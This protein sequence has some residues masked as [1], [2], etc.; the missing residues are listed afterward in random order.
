[1]ERPEF[2]QEER[3]LA[4]L[5]WEYGSPELKKLR[6]Q[7][8]TEAQELEYLRA[9]EA[10]DKAKR[11]DVAARYGITVEKKLEINDLIDMEDNHLSYCA[12]CDGKTCK[13]TCRPYTAPQPCKN[14]DEVYIRWGPCIVEETR[15]AEAKLPVEFRGKTLDDYIPWRENPEEIPQVLAAVE[16]VKRAIADR[17]TSLYLY[18]G[19]G[20]GKTLLASIIAKAGWLG[21]RRVEFGTVAQ[22]LGKIKETFDNPA[23]K[24]E[25]VFGRYMD[26]DLLVLDDIGAEQQTSW[27]VEQLFELINNRY[28]N[29]KQLVITSNF[30]PKEL[31]AEMSRVNLVK[32]GQIMSRLR[33][34]CEFG[35]TGA[36]DM[37]YLV[38]KG[39][40]PEDW[41]QQVHKVLERGNGYEEIQGQ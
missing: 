32:A 12:K 41:R 34:I 36:T 7:G 27:K 1:M 2:S 21:E 22:L 25:D 17:T 16:L 26:C 29:R 28:A 18:G 19:F 3:A 31:A 24:T 20:T 38:E 35:Y 4:R 14:G 10:K 30:S 11:A 5:S 40:V 13:K 23:L 6:A 39:L 37:R 33:T 8:L 9:V 15:R